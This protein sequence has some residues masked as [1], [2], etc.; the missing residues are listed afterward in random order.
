MPVLQPCL[1][2]EQLLVTVE[3]HTGMLQCHVPQYDAPLIP[4]LTNALNNDHSKLPRLI[5]ELRYVLNL[6]F[7]F[8]FFH[9]YVNF[10][11][12]TTL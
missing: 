9:S 4:E 3:T 10:C 11:R 12:D 1:R 8:F 5:S 7:T 6:Y 2:A